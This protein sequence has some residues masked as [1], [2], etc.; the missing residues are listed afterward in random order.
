MKQ[1]LEQRVAEYATQK[2]DRSII[3][4]EFDTLISPDEYDISNF[5]ALKGDS[6]FGCSESRKH[7]VHLPNNSFIVPKDQ[8]VVFWK[9]NGTW[10]A[11][12]HS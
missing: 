12:P 1:T 8:P 9:N 4:G 11:A 10:M 6:W 3:N 5:E 2:Q 7:L